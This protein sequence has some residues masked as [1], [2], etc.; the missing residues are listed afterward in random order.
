M[1]MSVLAP[2]AFFRPHACFHFPDFLYSTYKGGGTGSNGGPSEVL[3]HGVGGTQTSAGRGECLSA[4]MHRNNLRFLFA[5][6]RCRPTRASL[7]TP[8]LS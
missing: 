5:V 8:L 6:A 3:E 4:V 1:A 7:L 2:L